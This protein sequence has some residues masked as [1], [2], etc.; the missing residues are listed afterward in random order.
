M[1][2]GPGT[3]LVHSLVEVVFPKP[4]P[5]G[6]RKEKVFV[7]P[8]VIHV[9]NGQSQARQ[10]HFTNHTGGKVRLWFPNGSQLFAKPTASDFENPFVI[11]D[12]KD[13]TFTLKPEL[14]ECFYYYHVYC[15]V[16]H[17]EAEGNSPPSLSCP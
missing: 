10:I 5:V 8:G 3:V 7:E 17:D 2:N 13:L 15:D 4:V 14:G 12:G 11:P 6:R 1:P 9:G 16:V